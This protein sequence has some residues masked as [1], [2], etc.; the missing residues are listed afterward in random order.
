MVAPCHMLKLFM[1]RSGLHN[2]RSHLGVQKGGAAVAGDLEGA[3][4]LGEVPAGLQLLD[5]EQEGHTL[6]AGDL[7]VR[8]MCLTESWYHLVAM[9]AVEVMYED[10]A[11][12]L[13]W[14]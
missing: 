13:R 11:T 12:V 3:A 8:I 14:I 5:G 7:C 6:A 9:Q 2:G 10:A 1:R 4:K